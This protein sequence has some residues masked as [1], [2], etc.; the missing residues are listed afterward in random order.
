MLK[1]D[2]QWPAALA[3]SVSC[4]TL[5]ALVALGHIHPEILLGLVMWLI[6][7]PWRAPEKPTPQAPPSGGAH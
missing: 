3:F 6:P 1:L 7:G 2:L 5:G 4:A